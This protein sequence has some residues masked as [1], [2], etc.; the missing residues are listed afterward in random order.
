MKAL[1]FGISGQDGYYLSKLLKMNGVDVIGVS[2]SDGNWIKGSVADF[3][4][5]EDLIKK[6]MPNYIFHFAANSTTR[7]NSMFENQQSICVGTL[8]ILESVKLHC[9]NTKVFLSGSGLQFKNNGAAIDENTPYEASSSYAIAR[10]H[11]VYAARYYRNTFGLNIF[12]GYFFNHDSPLRSESHV[13]QKIVASLNRISNG[14]FEKLELGN[15]EVQ[16]EFNFAG[17]IVNA[18]WMLVNQNSIFEAV[19]GSGK[20]Y[21]IRDWLEYCSAKVHKHWP[22]FVTIKTEYKPEYRILVSEPKLIKSIG[23]APKVEFYEFADMMMESYIDY[24]M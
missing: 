5:V 6:Q 15:I 23:W 1:I 2:R 12:V 20:A 11:S 10:I 16:K 24:N 13:N 3:S 19:I 4:F 18:V 21:K 17:D 14:N 22:D 9:L 7:H 8:N